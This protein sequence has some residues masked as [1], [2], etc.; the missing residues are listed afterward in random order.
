MDCDKALIRPPSKDVYP[1]F[2]YKINPPLANGQ[3]LQTY[4]EERM[5]VKSSK[6]AR[7][8]AFMLCAMIEKVNEALMYLKERSCN[9]TA[10]LNMTYSVYDDPSNTR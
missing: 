6:E 9:G 7:R 4:E 8:E 5:P 10:N 2:D 1:R 3:D